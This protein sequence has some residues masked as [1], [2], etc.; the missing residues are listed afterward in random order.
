M[1]KNKMMLKKWNK[2]KGKK[3]GNDNN[4]NLKENKKTKI[5][6]KNDKIESIFYYKDEEGKNFIYNYYK[7]SYDGTYYHLRYKDRNY[8][9]LQNLV[10]NLK[11][12]L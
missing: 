9:E 4:N 1:N 6:E 5:K 2:K 12:L 10:L 3:L 7:F 11:I 8:Q